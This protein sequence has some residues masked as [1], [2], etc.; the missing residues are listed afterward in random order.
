VNGSTTIETLDLKK[1]YHR[2]GPSPIKPNELW[3]CPDDGATRARYRLGAL[4]KKERRKEK[5]KRE[6]ILAWGL[7]IRNFIT[8]PIPLQILICDA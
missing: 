5:E 4:P 2:S 7:S 1:S 8:R 3:T 6:M